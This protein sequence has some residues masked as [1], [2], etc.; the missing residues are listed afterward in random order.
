MENKSRIPTRAEVMGSPSVHSLTKQILELSENKD[1][2]DRVK[3]VELA[4]QV[5]KIEMKNSL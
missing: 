4:L 5:L 3:D 2:V 1:V